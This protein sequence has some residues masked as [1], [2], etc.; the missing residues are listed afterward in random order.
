MRAIVV[1]EFGDPEVMRVEEIDDPTPGPDDVLVRIRAAGVNPV[2]TYIR[3]GTYARKPALPYTPGSDGAGKVVD[4]GANATGFS[5]GQR[6]YV[7]G[8]GIDRPGTYAEMVAVPAS[9]VWPMPDRLS[10]EQGA[11]VAVPYAT[12][13]HAVHNKGRA[14]PNE[15]MLVHGATGAVGTAAVQMGV[16]LGMKVI[17]TAGTDEGQT[18]VRS[19]GAHHVVNHRA[20]NHI[21]EIK[22][23]TEGNG[24]DLIVELLA[25]VN[26]GMDLTAL[27]F[28]GR[29]V[30]VGS[31]GPVEINPRDIMSKDVTVTGMILFNIPDVE[32]T[33][34]HAGLRAGF[35]NGSLAPVIG[36]TYPLDSAPLAHRAILDAHAHGKIVLLP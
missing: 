29:V 15:W 33:R 24:V 35:T 1:R 25:N 8:V 6:V 30:I 13:Y 17:G 14:R 31:R 32:I 12:A 21:D 19:L 26:L 4:V 18:L 3:T 22:K 27:A 36:Q 9:S 2:E 10:Y 11:A 34:I 7:G 16:A 20:A 5:I 23:I 28:G